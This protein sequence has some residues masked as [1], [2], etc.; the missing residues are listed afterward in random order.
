MNATFAFDL[1]A[2]ELSL[3]NFTDSGIG[4]DSV[5]LTQ[6]GD[7][8]V[9]SLGDG[10]FSPVG[11]TTGLN[12]SLTNSNSTLTVFDGA[13]S[14]VGLNFD[15]GQS[16][17]FEIYL[18]DIRFGGG[19]I[20]I[21]G[22]DG[23]FTSINESNAASSQVVVSQFQFDAGELNLGQ[24]D[25]D[26]DTIQGT[27]INDIVVNDVNALSITSL[28][29][30]NGLIFVMAEGDLSLGNSA[31]GVVIS[32]PLQ[33]MDPNDSITLISSNGSVTVAG[34]V[35]NIAGASIALSAGT[36]ITLDS[37]VVSEGG[38]IALSTAGGNLNQTD[39][40]IIVSERLDVVFAG[41]A[42]LNSLNQVDELAATVGGDFSF[43]NVGDLDIV[44]SA[45][46]FPDGIT[47][48]GD[49]DLTVDGNLNQA[50]VLNVAGTSR[51]NVLGDFLDA[52]DANSFFGSTTALNVSGEIVLGDGDA[53]L[54]FNQQ[55]I[56]QLLDDAVS[57]NFLSISA[58]GNGGNLDGSD[59]VATTNAALFVD[60]SIIFGDVNIAGEL[61]VD[62]IETNS[63]VGDILQ[64][65]S[66]LQTDSLIQAGSAAFIASGSVQLTN[67]QFATVSVQT[68]NNFAA[69]I[70]PFQTNRLIG[71]TFTGSL[72]AN[73]L[74]GSIGSDTFLAGGVLPV[75]GV[76]ELEQ[77]FNEDGFFAGNNDFV[78]STRVGSIIVNQ[79][80]LQLV[81]FES[82][83]LNAVQLEDVVNSSSSISS[84][85]DVYVE[86][87]F[88]FDL[89]TAANVE[90]ESAASNATLVAGDEL[91]LEDGVEIRRSEAGELAGL[92]NSLFR[93]ESGSDLFE[94]NN[95]RSA[96]E[97]P[98]NAVFSDL[99]SQLDT[100]IGF[101]TFDLFFGNSGE[102]S[103]NLLIGWFQNN[104]SPS[105]AI[106]DSFQLSLE[107]N[108]ADVTSDFQFSDFGNFGQGV[109]AFLLDLPSVVASEQAP[110]ELTN[111]TQFEQS[112][113]AQESFL[114]SQVFVTND[115]RIN[116]FAN[117]GSTDLNFSQE[118]LPTRTVVENPA[119]IEVPLPTFD[120]PEAVSPPTGTGFVLASLIQERSDQPL[121]SDETPQ[122]YFQIKYTADDDGVYEEEFKWQDQNDDPDAIR[123]IIEE[124]SLTDDADFWPDT[125]DGTTG[126]WTELIKDGN[127]KPGL[128]F[129]F[130]VQE[131][132]LVPEPVDAPVDRTDLENLIEPQSPDTATVPTN[133]AMPMQT[134]SIDDT[135][136]TDTKLSFEAV[137][138]KPILPEEAQELSHISQDRFGSSTQQAMLGSSLLLC[139]AFRQGKRFD[140][141]QNIQSVC[142]GNLFSTAARI[143]R[144]H[145]HNANKNDR[146]T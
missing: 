26:F 7:D 117:A 50:T 51:L 82:Q 106:A 55:N 90:L 139:Q 85:G 16:T 66:S 142:P 122:S 128:Y 43:T 33:T 113:F 72:D 137:E 38:N 103:F 17:S 52:P 129:I 116:L 54:L 98:G 131:G 102:Q 123:S 49:L 125:T 95:P 36:E 47:V 138:P 132:E 71:S 6:S 37:N 73:V 19:S 10:A 100:S 69:Q 141:S 20:S 18:G 39:N 3:A 61:F 30:Q 94:L 24:N 146:A 4:D 58:A 40:S 59:V 109:S 136:A 45:L 34:P 31:N 86:T 14:L 97:A 15:P 144:K 133:E 64:T 119:I 21:G 48:G 46:S 22:N 63:I 108:L 140:L 23:L 134:S 96:F 77:E 124:A 92:V 87:N 11:S 5:E 91:T 79:T 104:V 56:E 135:I 13:T 74:S 60:S 107:N 143:A 93:N 110:L 42:N 127:V 65:M 9:F 111:V 84:L 1:A 121:L 126:N 53:V 75:S 145:R 118:L 62:T 8:F 28:Q 112:F 41:N 88:G 80:D 99:N 89:I 83:N 25:H 68:T 35:E 32:D 101:Q 12:F 70:Q 115:A 27:A 81:S 67:T 105:D 44:V 120:I 130:E 76:S 78:N 114:L 2:A 57:A 29:S